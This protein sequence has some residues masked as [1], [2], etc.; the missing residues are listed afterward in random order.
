[1][2]S[3][4]LDDDISVR[5]QGCKVNWKGKRPLNTNTGSIHTESSS[6]VLGDVH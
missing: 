6:I 5:Y 4:L 2:P 3:A 1:M